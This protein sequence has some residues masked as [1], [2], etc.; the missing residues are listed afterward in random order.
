MLDV[1]P[2]NGTAVGM[3][4]SLCC[5]NTKFSPFTAGSDFE[6]VSTTIVFSNGSAVNASEMFNVSIIDDAEEEI[7][8]LVLSSSDPA[9]IIV[10][11]TAVVTITDTDCKSALI[12][13][14]E[15]NMILYSQ[16][17]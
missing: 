1:Q 3:T 6:A 10:N 14:G 15:A 4:I 7:F 12:L 8:A 17:W 2:Y 11:P 13:D 16:L 9:A 5:S